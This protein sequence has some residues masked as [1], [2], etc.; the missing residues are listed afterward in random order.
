[1]NIAKSTVGPAMHW[2]RVQDFEGYLPLALGHRRWS[3]PDAP[4]K[5][6]VGFE[7]FYNV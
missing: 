4:F 3:P 6:W 7:F 1:M 2:S 5:E